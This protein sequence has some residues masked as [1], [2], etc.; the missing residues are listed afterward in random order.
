MKFNDCGYVL[1]FF[2]FF[3]AW[4]KSD[5]TYDYIQHKDKFASKNKSKKF[6]EAIEEANVE[7]LKQKQQKTMIRFDGKIKN[8]ANDEEMKMGD[9]ASTSKICE[10]T[11]KTMDVKDLLATF[12]ENETVL[13]S[14]FNERRKKLDRFNYGMGYDF[15]TVLSRIATTEQHKEMYSYMCEAIAGKNYFENPIYENLF[16]SI[17]LPEWFIAICMKKFSHTKEEVIAQ[18]KKDDEDSLKANDSFDLS[19]I[20]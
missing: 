20:D 12:E 4:I 1:L 8:G 6:Q 17:L 5:N 11:V 3:S 7:V 15:L 14:I 2:V 10:M 19:L 18:I 16:W 9:E 13:R